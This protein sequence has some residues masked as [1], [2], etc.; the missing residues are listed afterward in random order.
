MAICEPFYGRGVL[1]WVTNV[2]G[3]NCVCFF[4]PCVF[5]VHIIVVSITCCLWRQRDD[6]PQNNE[7]KKWRRC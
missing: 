5:V 4:L 6:M 7:E 1:L 2:V 3:A